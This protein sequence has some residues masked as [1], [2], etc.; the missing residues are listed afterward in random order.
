MPE[1]GARHLAGVYVAGVG[2]D[3]AQGAKRPVMGSLGETGEDFLAENFQLAGIEA[4]GDGWGADWSR[5]HGYS[6]GRSRLSEIVPWPERVFN[7][8]YPATAGDPGKVQK[9]G[10][11]NDY[12]TEF[13]AVTL[14]LTAVVIRSTA[15]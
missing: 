4:A 2:R 13:Q 12:Q 14:V 15:T 8:K 6:S 7:G 1:G 11:S 10:I 5:G 3:A 9:V